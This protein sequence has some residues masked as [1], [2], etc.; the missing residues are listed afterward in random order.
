MTAG[1][2]TARLSGA[3]S[4]PRTSVN[5][6]LTIL[7]TCWSDE[8]LSGHPCRRLLADLADE[9]LHNGQRDIGIQKCQTYLTKRRV[10]I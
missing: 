2:F 6:S 3:G 4:V 1:R 9:G 7:M 8:R 10:D 5:T